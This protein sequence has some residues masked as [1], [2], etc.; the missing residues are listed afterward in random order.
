MEETQGLKIIEDPAVREGRRNLIRYPLPWIASETRIEAIPEPIE[1]GIGFPGPRIAHF[2][3]SIQPRFPT[4]DK[5]SSAPKIGPGF[6]LHS[7]RSAE[8]EPEPCETITDSG[9]LLDANRPQP[10]SGSGP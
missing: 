4:L 8:K 6:L 2:A 5:D 9:Y 1:E 10:G 3:G 7:S